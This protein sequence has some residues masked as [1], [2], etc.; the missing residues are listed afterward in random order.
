MAKKQCQKEVKTKTA[1]RETE[2][3][4]IKKK[5]FITDLLSNAERSKQK[6]VKVAP[7]S[8]VLKVEL[9]KRGSQAPD[10]SV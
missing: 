7:P 2:V 4:K 8:K 9:R 3:S 5:T 10:K 1:L 6:Q